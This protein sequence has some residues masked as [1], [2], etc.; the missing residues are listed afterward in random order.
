MPHNRGFIYTYKTA[1]ATQHSPNRTIRKGE[2]RDK[3]C[4]KHANEDS[5]SSTNI[6]WKHQ[7]RMQNKSIKG[8]ELLH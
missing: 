8:S 6:K 5:G 4:T 7:K 2:K 1:K 3:P